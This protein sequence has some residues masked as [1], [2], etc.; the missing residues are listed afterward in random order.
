MLGRKI[1]RKKLVNKDTEIVLAKTGGIQ[2]YV[3]WVRDPKHPSATFSGHYFSTYKE[4][5]A[6][7][8]KRRH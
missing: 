2:P 1:L 3:T 5:L 6:D 4:G 8:N 7:F